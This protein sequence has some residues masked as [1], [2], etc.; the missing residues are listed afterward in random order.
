MKPLVNPLQPCSQLK[1]GKALTSEEM[2]VICH[3]MERFEVSDED[4]L[5]LENLE[6]PTDKELE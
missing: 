3:M 6:T 5:E 2:N 4:D 1:S